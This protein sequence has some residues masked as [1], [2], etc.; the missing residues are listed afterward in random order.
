M[1][2]FP[3][4]GFG[5]I[6]VKKKDS[7]VYARIFLTETPTKKN[8]SH[9]NQFLHLNNITDVFCFT[10]QKYDTTAVTAT[11]H[12]FELKDGTVP[13]VG[14]SSILLNELTDTFRTLYEKMDFSTTNTYNRRESHL[15]V[16]FHCDSG[17]GRAPTMLA[18]MM[19]T[20]FHIDDHQ[21]IDRIR[22]VRKGAFNT[23][24]LQWLADMNNSKKKECCIL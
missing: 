7:T 10:R 6:R 14:G 3:L 5:V 20:Y 15:N 23:K 11:V 12:R 22:K 16:M 24:Q 1:N 19:I 17:Y 18:Y 4:N 8:I 9:F 13:D 21:A 2:S